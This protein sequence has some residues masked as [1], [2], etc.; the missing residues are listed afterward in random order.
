MKNS[1]LLTGSIFL[2]FAMLWLPLGQYDFLL[3]NWMKIG[4]YAVP[5]LLIGAFSF[6]QGKTLKEL[7]THYRFKGI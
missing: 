1:S 2:L 3:E 5:F 6:Y 4:T 7:L